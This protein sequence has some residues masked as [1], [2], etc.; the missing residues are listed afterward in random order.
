[1]QNNRITRKFAVTIGDE[2]CVV[3]VENKSAAVQPAVTKMYGADC[4]WFANHGVPGFGQVFRAL[5]A[6]K[7]DSQPGNSSVTY[8]V[9]IDIEPLAIKSAAF[10][11]QEKQDKIREQAANC[12]SERLQEHYYLGKFAGKN[13]DPLPQIERTQPMPENHMMLELEIDRGYE[14]GRENRVEAIE[15]EQ[16]EREQQER[17]EEQQRQKYMDQQLLEARVEMETTMQDRVKHELKI[18]A[19]VERL[20]KFDLSQSHD[21]KILT[22]VLND[23]AFKT[24]KHGISLGNWKQKIRAGKHPEI[25]TEYIDSDWLFTRL[26][27]VI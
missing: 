18:V 7:N 20:R 2:S 4:F 17:R 16:Q 3:C 22:A 15:R 14:I 27:N 6:T 10:R 24:W 8:Q 23:I 5:R 19:E 25:A 1:M 26:Q 12:L 13:G 21:D 9:G 11:A